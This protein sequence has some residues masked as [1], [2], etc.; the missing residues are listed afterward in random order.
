MDKKINHLSTSQ[1]R[2]QLANPKV[3]IID[4]RTVDAYNGWKLKSEFRGGHIKSARSLPSKWCNYLDWLDI[5]RS[6]D[7][8]PDHSL[9]I[10]GYDNK[11]TESVAQCFI[12]AHYTDISVYHDFVSE[13][14]ADFELPM[15]HLSRHS[16]LVSA[17][18]LN[19]LIA[20]KKVPEYDNNKFVL[21]HA[22]YRNKGAYEEGHIPGAIKLDSNTLESPDTWNC[23]SPQELKLALEQSGI[24]YDTTVILYGRYSFPN[25]DDPFPG[26]SA[27]DLGAMRCAFLMLYAGVRDVRILNGGLQAWSD[28]GFKI[29][30]QSVARK[31]ISD[32]GQ[33]IPYR[34]NLIVDISEAKE[35]LQSPDKNLV[36]VRSWSEYIG[37]VSGYNYIRKKG[38]IPG[39]VFAN[40]GSDAYHMENYRNVDLTTREYHEI[41]KLWAGVN[42]TP[43]K[44]NSFYCGTGWRASE[45]WFNAWLMGW[46]NISVFDGGWFEWSSDELNPFETGL[47][48]KI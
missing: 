14:S 5:V 45:A 1:V 11:E 47:P 46:S 39:A 22:H 24:S 13:W 7:I 29:S 23:R 34:P 9:I 4:V 48:K 35:I 28:S 8:E 38:R 18:W 15:S 36:C 42:I 27:G 31:P 32:F 40:C 6:K 25:N 44:H 10:Y 41:K 43:D 12:K 17:Q 2:M 30:T 33:K 16:Q 26:S 3:K 21:C 37:E 19:D 20:N